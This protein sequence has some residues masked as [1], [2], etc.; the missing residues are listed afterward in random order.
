MLKKLK[1]KFRFKKDDQNNNLGI[2]IKKNVDKNIEKVTDICT[3]VEKYI[4][5]KY[6]NIY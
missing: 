4:L 3:I 5:K 6:Q 2:K 1:K